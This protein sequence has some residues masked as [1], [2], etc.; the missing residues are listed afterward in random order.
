MVPGPDG[1][2]PSMKALRVAMFISAG[3][4]FMDSVW[5]WDMAKPYPWE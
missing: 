1:A 5:A 2:G 4:P 3:T